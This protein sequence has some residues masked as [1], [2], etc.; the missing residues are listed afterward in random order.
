MKL[1]QDERLSSTA[2]P[3]PSSSTHR[4]PYTLRLVGE[5]GTLDVAP[6]LLPL[7][8]PLP[9]AIGKAASSVI[10]SVV[11]ELDELGARLGRVGLAP[12]AAADMPDSEEALC[13]LLKKSESGI[14]RSETR[15]ELAELLASE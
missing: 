8:L 1:H 2:Q 11:L 7:P 6:P 12:D 14:R 3:D 13:T 5:P 9:L 15:F 4:S 10:L